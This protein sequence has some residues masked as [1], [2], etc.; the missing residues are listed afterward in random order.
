MIE[1]ERQTFMSQRPSRKRGQRANS[2]LSIDL[3][4]TLKTITQEENITPKG[5]EEVSFMFRRPSSSDRSLTFK[6]PSPR[7]QKQKP[8]SSKTGNETNS[9]QGLRKERVRAGSH[10]PKQS[11]LQFFSDR[12]F[13][14]LNMKKK[15]GKVKDFVTKADAVSHISYKFKSNFEVLEQFRN[16]F[17]EKS[18]FGQFDDDPTFAKSDNFDVLKFIE[19]FDDEE[20]IVFIWE[21][22]IFRYRVDV[23]GFVTCKKIYKGKLRPKYF[24]GYFLYFPDFLTETI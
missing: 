23:K 16:V 2:G 12:K 20:G 19:P 7:T 11:K 13:S 15:K 4:N 21:H 9:D 10:G 3:S 17:E 6:T 8:K 1:R 18:Y 14:N 24:T 5:E 22:G